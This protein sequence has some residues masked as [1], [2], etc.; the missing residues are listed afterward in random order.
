MKRVARLRSCILFVRT[1]DMLL[2][3]VAEV[4]KTF[5]DPPPFET[6]GEFR[7]WN[8]LTRRWPC[9]ALGHILPPRTV[10]QH[11]AADLCPRAGSST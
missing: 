7:Y 9:T 1:A 5:G 3:A 8:Y 6:L 10:V 4:V 11:L 2:S